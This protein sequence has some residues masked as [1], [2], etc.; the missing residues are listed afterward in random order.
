MA[1]DPQTEAIFAECVDRI[2]AGEEL[3]SVL[4]SIPER[5]EEIRPLLESLISM[6]AFAPDPDAQFKGAARLRF[7]GA[8]RSHTLRE[9]EKA[10]KG[11]FSGG[12]SPL[13]RAWVGSAAVLVLTIG[14]GGGATVASASAMPES[15]LYGIKRLTERARLALTPSETLRAELLLTFA[16]ERAREL[17]VMAEEGKVAQVERLQRDLVKQLE[18]AQAERGISPAALAPDAVSEM[19]AEAAAPM[20]AAAAAKE[21]GRSVMAESAA[22]DGP[23]AARALAAPAPAA[24]SPQRSSPEVSVELRALLGKFQREYQE[25]LARLALAQQNA[26]PSARAALAAA[27]EDMRTRYL[28]VSAGGATEVS[29]PTERIVLVQGVVAVRDGT[30]M[31]GGRP[32]TFVKISRPRSGDFIVIG[33]IQLPDGSIRVIGIRRTGR[34]APSRD[35]VAIQAPLV[36]SGAGEIVVGDY[37]VVLPENTS[38]RPEVRPGMWLEVTGRIREDGSLLADSVHLI[39]GYPRAFGSGP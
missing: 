18:L 36:R 12:L 20:M 8:I 17:D 38:L 6:A 21:A 5:S 16:G 13:A 24:T 14:I 11:W 19:A 4:Q 39:G 2:Q 22:A 29:D 31:I 27:F 35:Y 28:A 15:P 25:H 34:E 23:Q 9:Q 10:A 26:S 30:V 3:E 7:H 32:V 1:T 33:G 37:T